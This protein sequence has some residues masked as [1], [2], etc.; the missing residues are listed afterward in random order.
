ML[1]NEVPL[2]LSKRINMVTDREFKFSDIFPCGNQKHL[3]GIFN[4]IL[5]DLAT[6]QLTRLIL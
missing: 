1:T 4:G 6:A 5:K 2:M 3:V